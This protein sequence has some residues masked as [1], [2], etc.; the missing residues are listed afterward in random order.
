MN[1]NVVGVDTALRHRAEA[2][3]RRA[4]LPLGIWVSEVILSSVMTPAEPTTPMPRRP[5][6]H[7]PGLVRAMRSNVVGFLFGLLILGG[8]IWGFVYILGEE[9]AAVSP[10]RSASSARI[11]STTSASS[12]ANDRAT[13]AH[14][15]ALRTAAAEGDPSAKTELAMIYLDGKDVTPDPAM[16]ARFLEEAAIEG[17]AEAQY[18]LGLLYEKGRGRSHDDTLAFF[19]HDSA[20]TRGSIPAAGRL[21]VLYAEGRGTPQD[22]TRAAYWFRRSAEAGDSTAQ[23]ALG[24]L[25]D[26]GLGVNA[27]PDEARRWWTQAAEKGNADAQA[28]IDGHDS[29][30]PFVTAPTSSPSSPSSTPSGNEPANPSTTPTNDN[31]PH[32]VVDDVAEIQRL[33]KLL[34][35]EPGNTDGHVTP[36]TTEA[37]RSYQD[38]AGLK[39]DGQPSEELLMSLR[40]VAGNGAAH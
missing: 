37:I 26:R 32:A 31:G 33:L 40:A 21:G 10:S 4:D 39:P 6:R 30:A 24:Y 14:L 38:I 7:R 9:E 25:Y 23:F 34:A 28:R 2:A 8:S 36:E 27:D 17:Y 1:W 16:A 18:Q 12:T 5:V 20:A 11:D 19:W 15:T 22:F 13:T 3:A 29:P 35:F